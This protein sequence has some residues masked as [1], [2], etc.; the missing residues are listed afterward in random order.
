MRIA[1]R[2]LLARCL[3]S[4]QRRIETNEVG[5]ESL[6]DAELAIEVGVREVSK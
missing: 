5:N 3:G 1:R 4:D 2:T 6:C